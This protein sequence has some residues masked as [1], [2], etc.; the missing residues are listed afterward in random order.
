MFSIATYHS[1]QQTGRRHRPASKVWRRLVAVSDYAVFAVRQ[2]RTL[3]TGAQSCQVVDAVAV[4]DPHDV[5]FDGRPFIEVRG[6]VMA[7]APTSLTPRSFGPPIGGVACQHHQIDVSAQQVGESGW[8]AITITTGM[9]NSPRRLRH[10]RSTRQ[11]S[12]VDAM[13][14]TRFGLAV[15]VR[16]SRAPTRRGRRPGQADERWCAA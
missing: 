10:S 4:I 9:S 11:W 5:L 15:S 8:L 12:S 16:R 6:H 13:R 3:D 7:V 2:H 1:E 14:A